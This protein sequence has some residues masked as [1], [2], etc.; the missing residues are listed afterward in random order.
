ML[1][2]SGCIIN[3]R[4]RAVSGHDMEIS[5]I[6]LDTA[7]ERAES[8]ETMVKELQGELR[9]KE[10]E[11]DALKEEV[12]D[13]EDESPEYPNYITTQ[14]GGTIGYNF[15]DKCTL[16]DEQIFEALQEAYTTVG[17]KKLLAVLEALR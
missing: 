3:Q 4:R 12:S 7:I 16:Q 14:M 17:D 1:L 2:Y 10:R 8:A 13:L 15:E 5:Q 9:D 11:I 6:E